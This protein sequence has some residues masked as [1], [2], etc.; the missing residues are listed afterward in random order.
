M[1]AK[2]KPTEPTV[3]KDKKIIREVIAQVRRKPS[4]ADL[5]WAESRRKLFKELTQ[6]E[7][8]R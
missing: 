7:P 4:A 1:A 6:N 2:I 8:Y 5:K 3:V